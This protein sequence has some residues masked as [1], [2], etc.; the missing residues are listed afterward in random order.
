MRVLHWSLLTKGHEQ[1]IL[2]SRSFSISWSF[3]WFSSSVYLE[4]WSSQHVC[5]KS[6]KGMGLHGVNSDLVECHESHAHLGFSDLQQSTNMNLTGM[7][8]NVDLCLIRLSYKITPTP[9]K[10]QFKVAS[11]L[12]RGVQELYEMGYTKESHMHLKPKAEQS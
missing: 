9:T 12:H 4:S 1:Y 5:H 10:G 8:A 3:T 6:R 11:D 2:C 7:W